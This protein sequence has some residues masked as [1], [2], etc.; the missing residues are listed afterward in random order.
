GICDIAF[1]VAHRRAKTEAEFGVYLLGPEDQTKTYG[2]S[3]GAGSMR[4]QIMANEE[5]DWTIIVYLSGDN[6]LAEETVFALKEMYRVGTS[7]RFNVVVLHDVGG[8]HYTFKIPEAK[9]A[10]K[11][12]R[13]G[14]AGS[15]L[16][17]STSTGGERLSFNLLSERE[18]F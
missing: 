4:E 14:T 11:V 3:T 16:Q 2:L 15:S 7:D 8:E 1:W 12:Q 18:P 5:K 6:N 9:L 13:V 10:T 17:A